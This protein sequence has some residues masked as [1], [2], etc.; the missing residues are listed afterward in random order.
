MSVARD[1]LRRHAR[2]VPNTS[3]PFCTFPPPSLTQSS[4]SLSDVSFENSNG[5]RAACLL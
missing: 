5:C 3:E 2:V 1:W 4:N